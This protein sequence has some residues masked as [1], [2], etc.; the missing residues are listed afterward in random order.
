MLAAKAGILVPLDITD[1]TKIPLIEIASFKV[2]ATY[3]NSENSKENL[4][5]FDG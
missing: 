1:T 2:S 4:F 3:Y 5:K